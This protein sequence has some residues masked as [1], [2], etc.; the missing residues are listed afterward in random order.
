MMV[1]TAMV[2][3]IDVFVL[4][5]VRAADVVVVIVVAVGL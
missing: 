2:T 1:S 3:D 5:H 4:L